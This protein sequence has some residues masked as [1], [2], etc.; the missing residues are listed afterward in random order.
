M[1]RANAPFERWVNRIY[2]LENVRKEKQNKN[3]HRRRNI[4][5]VNQWTLGLAAVGLVS[6][7]ALVQAEEKASAIM[8]ALSSTTISGYVDTSAHWDIG[9]GNAFVPGF[10]Y[11]AGKQDGFNLN[12]VK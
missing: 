1:V 8:T 12:K 10:I 11:N 2:P 9:T 3:L 4:M 7:P 6:L 5:K